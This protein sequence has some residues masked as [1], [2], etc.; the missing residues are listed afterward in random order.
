MKLVDDRDVLALMH[1]PMRKQRDYIKEKYMDDSKNIAIV[2]H[3]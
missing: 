1:K 2:S 3:S